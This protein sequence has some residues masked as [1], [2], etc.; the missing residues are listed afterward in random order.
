MKGFKQNFP[1]FDFYFILTKDDFR[2][3][4]TRQARVLFHQN[5]KEILTNR[6]IYTFQPWFNTFQYLIGKLVNKLSNFLSTWRVG[7]F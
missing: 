6:P 1:I 2:T 5:I 4:I 7:F 3:D